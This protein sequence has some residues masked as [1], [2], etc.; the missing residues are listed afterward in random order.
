M[1]LMAWLMAVAVLTV[2]P[3]H[4]AWKQY[5]STE[6]GFAVDFPA[7]VKISKGEWKAAVARTAPTTVVSAELDNVTYQAIVADFSNRVGDTPS[8]MGEAAYIL[9]LDGMLVAETMARSEPGPNAVYG[10]R[11]T[12]LLKDG[13]K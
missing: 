9:S 2:T 13:S 11:V 8:I 12:T 4:A 3:A 10:R 5:K 6:L 7:D 1:R